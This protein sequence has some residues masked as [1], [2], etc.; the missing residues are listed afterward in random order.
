MPTALILAD[1]ATLV[2]YA[3]GAGDNMLLWTHTLAVQ[4]LVEQG[5]PKQADEVLE[6]SIY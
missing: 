5:I 6:E 2:W 4:I 3:G 1:E